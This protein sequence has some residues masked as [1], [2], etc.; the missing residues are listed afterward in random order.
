MR[1]SQLL[2]ETRI[3][4]DLVVETKPDLLARMAEI[5]GVDIPSST[6]DAIL[7]VFQERE[8]L[9]TTGVGN[10]IAIPH[11]RLSG[12][13]APMAAM[14]R[15]KTGIAYAAMDDQPVHLVI[16]LLS[17]VRATTPHLKALATISR[18]LRTPTLRERLMA[19]DDRTTLFNILQSG[20]ES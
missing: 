3:D 15:C 11:G 4:P 12:L 14:G 6:P 8:R 17:P 18:L 2:T 19:A 1:I 5:L 9:G 16:A 10:G 20:E 13:S 7:N